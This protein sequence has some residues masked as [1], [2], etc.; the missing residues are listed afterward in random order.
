MDLSI[1]KK[2]SLNTS[3]SANKQGEEKFIPKHDMRLKNDFQTRS[4]I[5]ID[6]F[7]KAFTVYPA[8]GITGNINADFY[9]FLTMGTVP[10]V[11]GSLTLMGVFNGLRKYFNVSENAK[12]AKLGNKAALGV[13][14]YGVFKNLSKSLINYPV[15]WKTGIDTQ[16]P[17]LKVYNELPENKDDTDVTSYEYHKVGESV[18]FTRWDML[19]GKPQDKKVLNEKFDKIAKRNGL[20]EDLNDS[21]QSVKPMYKEVLVKSS[22]AKSISSYLWAATGVALS[23]QKPWEEFFRAFSLNIFKPAEVGHTIKLFFKDF[24]QSFINLYKGP[25]EPVNKLEKYGGKALI[26]T[27]VAATGLGL[28]NTF[29]INRKPAKVKESEILDKNKESVVG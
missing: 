7:T 8:R 12:S 15:K 20:G 27:S 9:E 28:L 24:K 11:I 1:N 22:L 14:M 19:Y 25:L 5:A 13:L 23:F 18:E 21:D 3:F 10:Y 6:K 26:W 4:R 2:T 16:L 29:M 17:Y